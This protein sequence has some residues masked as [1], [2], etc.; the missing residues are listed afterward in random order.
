MMYARVPKGKGHWNKHP[1]KIF[2]SQ[3]KILDV[4]CKTA[5]TKAFYFIF[6]V[7]VLKLVL[8]IFLKY[9]SAPFLFYTSCK[10]LIY[11]S[12]S[13]WIWGSKWTYWTPVIQFLLMIHIISVQPEFQKVCNFLIAEMFFNKSFPLKVRKFQHFVNLDKECKIH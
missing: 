4:N 3:C 7:F 13:K 9:L 5:K 12:R 8:L 6:G 1:R 10:S 2:S 11:A